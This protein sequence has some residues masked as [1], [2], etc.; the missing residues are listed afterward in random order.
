VG[1]LAALL[2]VLAALPAPALT[3]VY[4]ERSAAETTRQTFVIEPVAGGFSVEVSTERAGRVVVFQELKTDPRFSVLS[5]RWVEEAEATDVTAIR[6]GATISLAGLREGRKIARKFTVG[7]DPWYQ[8][9]PVGMEALAANSRG[10]EKFWAIGTTGILAMRIGA[11]RAVVA[12]PDQAEWGGKLVP[13]IRVRIS[14]AGPVSILWHG[15]F[16]HRPGDG[17]YLACVGNRGP[18]TLPLRVELTEER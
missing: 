2:L 18:G 17:R 12:G 4:T 13:A 7:D 8:V 16:W 5:W 6:D 3:L 14:M 10:S 11:F 15:D 9:F 1:F